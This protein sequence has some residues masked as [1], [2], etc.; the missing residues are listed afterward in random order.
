MHDADSVRAMM[1]WSV[2]RLLLL[3][4]VGA[5]GSTAK[6]GADGGGGS[7]AAGA[8]GTTG[9]GGRGGGSGGAAGSA[10]GQSGGGGTGGCAPNQVWCSGCEPGTGAC[11]VGGCPGV[12]CPPPDGG[13]GS[14]G[15]AGGGAN[16]SCH[17]NSDC[18]AGHVCYAGL[19]TT[20]AGLLLGTCVPRLS[21]QCSPTTG[22]G[23]RCLM[24]P[25]N[26]MCSAGGAYCAGSDDPASCWTC[27]LPQ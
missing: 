5:C 8:G 12:A 15:A 14:G 4:A 19:A 25:S 7:N 21:T 26:T 6:P 10:G 13:A 27:K 16:G 1:R 18:A 3:L 22:A 23:C 20:C 9:G 11:Y 2:P 24:L 17:V